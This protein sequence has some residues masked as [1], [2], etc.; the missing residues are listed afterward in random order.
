MGPVDRFELLV[1]DLAGNTFGLGEI[2]DF[3]LLVQAAH[4]AR[5][6]YGRR[7]FLIGACN[8]RNTDEN[9]NGLTEE[10]QEL[11]DEVLA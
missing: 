4:A 8:H 2:S 11:V 7:E 9:D 10:Q 1:T 5:A 6:Q 3:G